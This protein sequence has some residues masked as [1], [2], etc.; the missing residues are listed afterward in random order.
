MIKWIGT[1]HIQR[2]GD[3][4]TA[5][6]TSLLAVLDSGVRT[7][8]LSEHISG[9]RQ[10]IKLDDVSSV[11]KSIVSN[12]TAGGKLFDLVCVN[13]NCQHILSL[14]RCDSYLSFAPVSQKW[15]CDNANCVQY[16]TMY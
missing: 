8:V 14:F 9:K 16:R 10:S 11:Q 6:I 12:G 4:G 7:L 15:R 3:N 2:L 1:L 5:E 13:P